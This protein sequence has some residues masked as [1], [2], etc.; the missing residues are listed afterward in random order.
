MRLRF[1][2]LTGTDRDWLSVLAG[3]D[4]LLEDILVWGRGEVDLDA[5]I[6]L[7]GTQ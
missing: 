1:Q 6:I 7:Q 5:G 3:E 2:R 4:S